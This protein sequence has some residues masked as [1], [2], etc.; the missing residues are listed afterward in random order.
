[1]NFVTY[2]ILWK[3]GKFE[4]AKRYVDIN[5]KLIEVLLDEESNR[6]KSESQLSVIMEH[7]EQENKFGVGT[8][9]TINDSFE[10]GD[11]L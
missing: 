1:M 2:L 3:I 4:E 7:K 5:K 10:T 8:S 6:R 11:S 9:R